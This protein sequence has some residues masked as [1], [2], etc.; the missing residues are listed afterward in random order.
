MKFNM[1]NVPNTFCSKKGRTHYLYGKL[2]EIH[3]P[4]K[5]TERW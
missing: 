2:Y 3:I 4:N 1:E 5:M